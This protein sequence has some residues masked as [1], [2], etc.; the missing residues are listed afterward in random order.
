MSTTWMLRE[1]LALAQ[2]EERSNWRLTTEDG[3]CLTNGTH[4]AWPYW[5]HKEDGTTDETIV[6][7]FERYGRNSV[8]DL[9]IDLDAVS[10][11]DSNDPDYDALFPGFEEED[12]E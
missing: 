3:K 8:E 1:P 6:T 9:A 5:Q 2:V 4:Y 11:H 7:G 12:A 10:E